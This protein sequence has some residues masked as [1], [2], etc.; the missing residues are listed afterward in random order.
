M[1]HSGGEA[2]A[3]VYPTVFRSE[4]DVNDGARL[5]QA[6]MG[7]LF[8][9]YLL[10]ST[11]CHTATDKRQGGNQFYGLAIGLSLSLGSA[12]LGPISGCCLNSAVW[13]GTVVPALVTDQVPYGLSDIWVYWVGTFLGLFHMS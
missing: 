10:C 13:L 12:C 8:F 6:F 4:E 1:L 11:V 9:T 2:S 3:A 5:F 7:E